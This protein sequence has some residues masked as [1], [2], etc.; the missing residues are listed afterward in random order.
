MESFILSS[1][2]DVRP[3][4][5]LSAGKLYTTHCAAPFKVLPEYVATLNSTTVLQLSEAVGRLDVGDA[6]GTG[7][8]V[9]PTVICTAAHNVYDQGSR[10][11]IPGQR[12]F[13]T[14]IDDSNPTI[15]QSPDYFHLDEVDSARGSYYDV[16]IDP[17]TGNNP[18]VNCDFLFL[19]VT[20]PSQHYLI[21]TMEDVK[22]I[23]TIGYPVP[24]VIDDARASIMHLNFYND[25]LTKGFAYAFVHQKHVSP[26]QVLQKNTNIIAHSSSTFKGSSGSPLVDLSTGHF[27]GIHTEGPLGAAHNLAYSVQHPVFRQLYRTVVAPT[28]PDAAKVIVRGVYDDSI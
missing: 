2:G 18:P 23:V 19:T 16:N 25:V 10:D 4:F 5:P 12:E 20:Q 24:T 13:T 14:A 28:L 11:L 21:P 3:S 26:G 17:I 1:S 7:F 6:Q 22:N 15:I 9:S 8:Y 27:V